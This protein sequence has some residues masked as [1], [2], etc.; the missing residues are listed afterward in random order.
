MNL[1]FVLH[2]TGPEGRGPIA[3]ESTIKN[4]PEWARHTFEFMVRHRLPVLT[5]G[6]YVFQVRGIS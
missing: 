6:E 3:L 1:L 4:M 5:S 2:E